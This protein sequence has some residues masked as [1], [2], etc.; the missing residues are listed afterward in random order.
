MNKLFRAPKFTYDY[1]E[2]DLHT[3]TH[4]QKKINLMNSLL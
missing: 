1:I 3:I 2:I 4:T